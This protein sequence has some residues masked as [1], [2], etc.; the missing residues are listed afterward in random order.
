[1]SNT[2]TTASQIFADKSCPYLNRSLSSE[3]AFG[4]AFGKRKK[5][6]HQNHIGGTSVHTARITAWSI[7]TPPDSIFIFQPGGVSARL[8]TRKIEAATP[9]FRRWCLY[10]VFALSSSGSCFA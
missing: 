5:Y 6:S 10:F 1:M 2:E 8:T 9:A 4:N 7:F 3:S